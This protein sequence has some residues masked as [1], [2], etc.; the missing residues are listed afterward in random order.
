MYV[1]RE[2][3]K[4][5][6]LKVWMVVRWSER[7]SLN[8]CTLYVKNSSVDWENV[9]VKFTCLHIARASHTKNS[10]EFGFCCVCFFFVLSLLSPARIVSFGCHGICCWA[11][12]NVLSN[13]HLLHDWYACIKHLV[14]PISAHLI[15]LYSFRYSW[16]NFEGAETQTHTRT[17]SRFQSNRAVRMLYFVTC[18]SV[19]SFF[20]SGGFAF[21]LVF[22][23]SS[24]Y[25]IARV[26][27]SAWKNKKK[28]SNN[29]AFKYTRTCM[30][31][32]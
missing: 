24:Y 10:P 15:L 4:G 2:I 21:S 26:R 14:A 30:I 16:K 18:F 11:G 29:F 12:N 17:P 13:V 6:R 28:P 1:V 31:C 5:K 3:A 19:R 23:S 9:S 20:S 27:E 22:H 32:C 25:F 7:A 8:I